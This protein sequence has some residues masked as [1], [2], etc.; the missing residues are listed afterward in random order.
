MDKVT[1]GPYPVYGIGFKIG[2]KG[3]A[4]T[5]AE[6][7][8]IAGAEE[9]AL[10]ISSTLGEWTAMDGEGWQDALMTGKAFSIKVKAKRKVGDPGNDYIDSVAFR[11]GLDCSTKGSIEFPDGSKL[12]YN[13]VVD[14][15][16]PPGGASTDVAG[17]EF[18]LKGA[19]KPVYTPSL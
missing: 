6:M 17:L 2:T 15:T 11:N 7:V 14:V 1:Y 9:F 16:S 13:C 4:S 8:T 18:E 3:L 10:S 5:D 19:G 12:A